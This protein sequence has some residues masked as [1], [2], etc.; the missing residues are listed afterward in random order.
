M[1]I[2]LVEDEKKL[3]DFITTGLENEGFTMERA[4]DG[5][6]GLELM[7][8]GTHDVAI[9]DLMLPLKKGIDVLREARE[10]GIATPVLILTAKDSIESKIEGFSAGTDDYLTKPFHFEELLARLRALTR[11][12][13]P[14][15]PAALTIADL[16]LDLHAH[17]VT[18]GGQTIELTTKE[19]P[20]LEYFIRNEGVVLSRA[21]IIEHA[22]KEFFDRNTNLLDVY[23]MYLRKKMDDGFTPR[24]IHTVRGVGYLF[25]VR[26]GA[27]K[28]THKNE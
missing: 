12:A 10:Q 20:L 19:F 11:R 23:V 8:N 22:W 7:L 13:A 15:A 1:K 16:T 28:D 6:K 9:L 14:G 25:G 5:E 2:L 24:L 21:D 4:F 18:R 27:E 26:D 17:T 3:N